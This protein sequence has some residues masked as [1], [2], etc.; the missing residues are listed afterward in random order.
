MKLSQ[1]DATLFYTLMWSLQF[2]VNQRVNIAP[3]LETLEEYKTCAAD[4]KLQVREA[5]CENIDLIDAF[6]QANPEGFS[7][8]MLAIIASWKHLVAGNFY[9][10]RY[11]KKY[12]VFI[13]SDNNV[14][15]VLGLY[16]AFEDLF[17]RSRLPMYV[18]AVLLP[19][20]DTII[21]DGLLQ[22]YNV[23]FGRGITSNLKEIYMAAKQNGRI[24]ERLPAGSSWPR[25]RKSQHPT[26]E[27]YPEL[28]DLAARAKQLR[29]SADQPPVLS[30]ALTL[31]KASVELAQAAVAAPDDVAPLWL[32]LKKVRR[33]ANRVETTLDRAER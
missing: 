6:I 2:F 21:Y 22:G 7:A 10:E 14:Y 31:V 8:D 33:A 13:S 16:D 28:D 11:L 1:Q 32:A 17:P 5:L 29:A 24:I 9:I 4:V 20:K 18:K 3:E 26:R 30:P 27:G 23:S 12:T 15:A 19:F 25:V